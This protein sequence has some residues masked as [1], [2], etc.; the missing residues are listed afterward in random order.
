MINGPFNIKIIFHLA[1]F[2]LIIE[3]IEGKKTHE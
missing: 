1:S 3:N 2:L